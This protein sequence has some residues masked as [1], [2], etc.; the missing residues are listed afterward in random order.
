MHVAAVITSE[1]Y[2]VDFELRMASNY[3]SLFQQAYKLNNDAVR[4]CLKQSQLNGHIKQEDLLKEDSFREFWKD[5]VK[6]IW[7]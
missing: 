1:Y 4:I 2:H 3:S 5:G 7:G 6:F